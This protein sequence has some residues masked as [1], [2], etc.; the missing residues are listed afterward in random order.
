MSVPSS[1]PSSDPALAQPSARVAQ[2]FSAIG[3]LYIHLFTAIFATI[4]L[5][6]ESDW[7]RPYQ[8]LLPL[9]TLGSLL[10]GAAAI[11]AGWLAD[12]WTARGM[13]AVFFFGIGAGSVLC[14]FATGPTTLMAS[15]AVIGLFAAIYHP[16]G[17]PWVVRTARQRGKALG[18]NGIFGNVGGGSAALVAGILID[19]AGWR[20]AFIVPGVV[21]IATGFVM[22]WFL[23]R[24]RVAEGDNDLSAPKSAGRGTLMRA[25]FVLSFVMF[26]TGL[27]YHTTQNAMPKLFEL[28]L[29]SLFDGSIAG[30]GLMVFVVY[31]ISGVMQY[32]G[33]HIADRY[34]LKPVYVMCIMIQTPMLLLV[35]AAVG[36]PLLP[37]V[38]LSIILSTA[39][40]PAENLMLAHFA[41]AK[42]RS[43]S[44]G[45]KYVLSFGTAPLALQLIAWLSGETP[46]GGHDGFFTVFVALSGLMV[47][48]SIV[49]LAL[50]SP[51]GRQ[52]NLPTPSP[53]PAE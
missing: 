11:P 44:F 35:A 1:A 16:V 28:R 34:P 2:V 48:A 17:I 32:V 50:P 3:H 12:R 31:T 42:H 49:V 26:C 36:L 46:F 39:M 20:A 14:G 24:G 6:I 4:V 13:M 10:V 22:V 51:Q 45:M 5:A 41:P 52:T 37:A 53:T 29:G 23:M 38:M 27:V 7:H 25:F 8:E 40:L 9:W 30:V 33:G 21:A 47:L 18:L 43:L 15:L 19:A